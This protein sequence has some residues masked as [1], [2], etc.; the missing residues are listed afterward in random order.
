MPLSQSR[1]T[2]KAEVRVL[3]SE[4]TASGLGRT[5]VVSLNY[6][7]LL[8]IPS[9]LHCPVS[10]SE[11]T[12][13]SPVPLTCPQWLPICPQETLTPLASCAEPHPVRSGQ[14]LLPVFRSSAYFMPSRLQANQTT[15]LLSHLS[16]PLLCLHHSLSPLVP[17]SLRVLRVLTHPVPAKVSPC[18]STSSGFPLLR[19]NLFP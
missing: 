18:P 17:Q 12:L 7:I 2:D 15:E 14:P 11:T 9:P 8:S 6:Q 13:W 10:C 19:G 16:V 4:S 3:F 5:L 1:E